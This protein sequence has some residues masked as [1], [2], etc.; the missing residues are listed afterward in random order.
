MT[1]VKIDV[2]DAKYYTRIQESANCVLLNKLNYK[3][4][5]KSFIESLLKVNISDKTYK[6]A[7]SYAKQSKGDTFTVISTKEC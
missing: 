7:I 6:S 2:I 1:K 3:N 4:Y 5:D